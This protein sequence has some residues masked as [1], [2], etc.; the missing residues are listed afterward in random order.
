MSTCAGKPLSRRTSAV[1]IVA[2]L[3]V[4]AERARQALG[5]DAV[6]R[7]R[8]EERLDPHLDQ[9]GDRRRRVVGVQRREDEVAGER[10]LDRDLRRLA[11]ADLADHDDVG[12]GAHHRA[13]AVGERQAGARV[14]LDLGD[15]LDLE[16]DRVL[17]R[18]DVLLGGVEHPERRVERRRLARAGRAGDEHR[19]VGLVDRALEARRARRSRHAEL[20]EVVDD[21]AVLVEDAHRRSTRRGRSAASR[22]A[23]RR[24]CRRSSGR[25]GRPA[26]RAARRCR[27]RS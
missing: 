4:L 25:R 6:D 20:V 18:D 1:R 14:D 15:A 19:A 9:A 27:G 10:R 26:A 16:L 13:Q 22:R 12:V 3:A 21:G 24:A 23:G 2:L 5:D 8:D 7:A 17:D 11:V